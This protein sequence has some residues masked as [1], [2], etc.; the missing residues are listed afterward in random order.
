MLIVGIFTSAYGPASYLKAVSRVL[1]STDCHFKERV[2]YLYSLRYG[3]LPWGFQG[4]KI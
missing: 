3:K 1:L 2:K 4:A